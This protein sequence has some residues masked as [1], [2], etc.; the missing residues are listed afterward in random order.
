[1]KAQ[2]LNTEWMSCFETSHFMCRSRTRY[3]NYWTVHYW[4]DESA[5][6]VIDSK[7]HVQSFSIFTADMN[8]LTYTFFKSK[9]IIQGFYK[10]KQSIQYVQSELHDIHTVNNYGFK[11]RKHLTLPMAHWNNM[12]YMEILYFYCFTITIPNTSVWSVWEGVWLASCW[13]T[14]LRTGHK[15]PTHGCPPVVKEDFTVKIN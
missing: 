15:A 11:E 3:F 6:G 9:S 8:A 2:W 12:Q 4:F 14:S 1:M 13:S 10:G 7:I 5:E